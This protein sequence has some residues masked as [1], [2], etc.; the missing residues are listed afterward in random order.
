MV[1]T[2]SE[3]TNGIVISNKDPVGLTN[4]SDIIF[5]IETSFSNLRQL[6]LKTNFSILEQRQNYYDNIT[7]LKRFYENAERVLL[8]VNYEQ[9]HSSSTNGSMDC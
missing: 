4:F 8:N 5:E 6:A 1:E 9:A 2:I 3:I 7:Q